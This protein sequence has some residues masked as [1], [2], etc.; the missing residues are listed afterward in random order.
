MLGLQAST[1]LVR[2]YGDRDLAGL[3][4]CLAVIYTL[5]PCASLKGGP[6]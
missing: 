1:T 6:G 2:V 3:N 5:A 4:V